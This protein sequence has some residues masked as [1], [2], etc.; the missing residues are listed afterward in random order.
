MSE[1]GQ[2]PVGHQET[3]QGWSLEAGEWEAPGTGQW[4]THTTED[5][6]PVLARAAG[7][8]RA[9]PGGH[10]KHLGHHPGAPS[11]RPRQD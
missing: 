5:Q 6:M 8:G 11:N 10:V 9:R 4:G 7:R 2:G 3:K 1:A